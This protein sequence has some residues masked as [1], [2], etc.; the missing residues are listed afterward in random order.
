M[1]GIIRLLFAS[2]LA[3]VVFAAIGSAQKVSYQVDTKADFSRYKTYQWQRA[4]K[5]VYPEKALDDMFVR[6]IDA[7]L[8]KRGLSRTEAGEADLIV[9]YQIA[10]LDDME[11]SAGHSTIPMQSNVW[12]PATQGGP[13]GGSY[14]IKKGSFILD[15]YDGKNK[16]QIWQAH[17][18]KTL[19]DTTDLDKRTK[20]TQK[21]MAKIFKNYPAR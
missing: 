10:V 2:F 17:A 16:N 8:G 5:A 15:L 13:V 6:A 21:A 12:L 19:A 14:A 11:W 3:L 18:T 1:T 20:N 7:E 9:I 4:E